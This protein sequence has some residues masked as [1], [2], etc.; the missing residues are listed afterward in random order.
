VTVYPKDELAGGDRRDRA[1][2]TDASL[3]LN[4]FKQRSKYVMILD[5][6]TTI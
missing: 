4:F 5:N 3:D 6:M 2:V 1:F